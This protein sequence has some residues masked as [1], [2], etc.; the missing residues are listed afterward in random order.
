MLILPSG[1]ITPRD[2]RAGWNVGG[3]AEMKTIIAD[4]EKYIGTTSLMVDYDHQ[5]DEVRK[6]GGGTA[7][8]AGWIKKLEA[9]ND[10]IWAKIEWTEKA[11]QKI[12]SGE[13]KYLS[14]LFTTTAKNQVNMILNVGLVN[15]PAL[16]IEAIAAAA[17]ISNT[18]QNQM[19]FM[20]KL[21]KALGLKE[22]ASEDAIIAAIGKLGKSDD[23]TNQASVDLAVSEALKPVALA[24]GLEE[25]TKAET[26][27]ATVKTFAEG[28]SDQQKEIVALRAGLTEATAELTELKN[29]VA[30]ENATSIVEKAME[31]GCPIPATMK[32]HYINRC[33]AD[34][35]AVQKE[36]AA[37]PKTL[38]ATTATAQPPK[39]ADGTIA[40][41]AEQKQAA[42]LLGVDEEAYRNTLEA[43]TA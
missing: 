29:S 6:G 19:N 9:R 28:G 31:D 4:T 18:E 20:E 41:S 22:D 32:D 8:A 3:M 7:I 37:M 21:I 5:G 38:A 27:I 26:L 14:P 40:L 25:D 43:Q 34:P 17:E 12:K 36:I 16:D 23:K 39:N 30:K 13:Y 24:A 1:R 42:T 11:R 15:M 10:G 2:G 35:E 33:M